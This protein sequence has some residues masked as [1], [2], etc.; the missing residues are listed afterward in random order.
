M[1][2][3]ESSVYQE[4]KLYCAS[5]FQSSTCIMFT[6]VPGSKQ[7]TWWSQGLRDD[8]LD[9]TSWWTGRNLEQS[10]TNFKF[11]SPH[12]NNEDANIHS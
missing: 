10:I 9:S 12:M 7:I 5:V 8:E 6:D 11:Q 2:V 3:P 1:L 4:S